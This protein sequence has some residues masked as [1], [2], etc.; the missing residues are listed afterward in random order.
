MGGVELLNKAGISGYLILLLSIVS[1]AIVFEKLYVL[2]LGKLVPKDD[3]RLLVEFLGQGNIGDA[4]ELCKRRRSLLSAV[5]FDAIKNMGKQTRENFLHAFEV[6]ARRHFI[7][8]ERGMALLAITAATSPLLGLLG[9]VLGM[10]KIFGALT[11]GTGMGN[12]QE[13]SA[14]I[15]EALL[16]TIMGLIVAIPAI[17]MY[18]IFNKKLD[19]IAAEIEAA[20]VLLANNFKG[21]S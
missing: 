4:V 19:K 15:A 7:E 11:G 13:L 2:R 20:G 9:T 5:V 14:G 3:L 18:N 6:S 17:A 21:L 10:V 12:P 16:T 8:L 1:L